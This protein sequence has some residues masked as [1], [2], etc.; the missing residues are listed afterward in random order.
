MKIIELSFHSLYVANK[1]GAPSWGA[2]RGGASSGGRRKKFRLF[3]PAEF[4]Q[5]L[6]QGVTLE[7]HA[8]RLRLPLDPEPDDPGIRPPSEDAEFKNR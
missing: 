2:L 1:K 8:D 7:C 4:H 5:G 3:E 6:G